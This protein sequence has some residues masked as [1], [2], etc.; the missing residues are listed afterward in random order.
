MPEKNYIK[1]FITKMNYRI[2][3]FLLINFGALAIG[4]FFTGKGVPSDWYEGLIK[5]PDCH[6]IEWICIIKKL[7]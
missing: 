5:A 2:I 1:I 4:S 6:I 3:I 7:I